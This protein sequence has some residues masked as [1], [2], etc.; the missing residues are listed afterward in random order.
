MTSPL[1][2]HDV[3]PVGYGV[4]GDV[5]LD[6]GFGVVGDAVSCL[7]KYKICYIY[8]IT[9]K[10]ATIKGKHVYRIIDRIMLKA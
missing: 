8:M 10:C 3:G 9:I 6:V 5:G 7:H 2:T 1:L 4:V